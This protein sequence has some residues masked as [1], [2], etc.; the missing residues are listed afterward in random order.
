MSIKLLATALGLLAAANLAAACSNI[1]VTPGASTDGS[2]LVGDN[3]DSSRR[4]GLVSHWPAADHPAGAMREIWDFDSGEF[5]GKIP[6]PKHT[7]NVI[8]R[9][10]EKD[11]IMAETTHGSWPRRR[12]EAS[13][14][15]PAAR[16]TSWTTAR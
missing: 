15:S 9:A 16:A 13:P 12:M 8:S 6:Q 4:H 2:A 7:F 14:I 11:V 10:N 1:L 5:N 3:D